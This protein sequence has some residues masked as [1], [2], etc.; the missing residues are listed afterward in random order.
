MTAYGLPT[1]VRDLSLLLRGN[2]EWLRPWTV[3]LRVSHL[4]TCL[5][6]IVVGG[7]LYGFAMGFWRD[8]LQGV[9]VAVKLPLIILLTSLGNTV[10]NSMLAPLLGLSISLR[11]SFLAILASF[12]IA[13]C[14]MGAF[15]PLLAFVV[16]NVQPLDPAASYSGV[17]H[18]VILLT[19][20]LIIAFA[21]TAAN[22]HLVGLLR[23]LSGNARIARRV[24]LAWLAGNLFLGSQVAWLFRPFIGSPVL[25]IEFVRPNAFDGNFYETVFRAVLRIFTHA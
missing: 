18:S 10:V 25:P 17:G 16:C 2:P 19:N 8:P 11:Q 14:I 23:H 1:T 13:G 24:L 7:G 4:N 5:V 22:L 3:R 6:G 21:G 9:Y 20:V 12:A 15:S